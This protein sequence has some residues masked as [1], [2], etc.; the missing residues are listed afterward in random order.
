MSDA[1]HLLVREEEGILI[2]T[3]NRPDKLKAMS[4]ELTQAL[5]EAVVQF[6]DTPD[7]KWC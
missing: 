2:A 3:F 5:G 6:R 7:L 1:P 4:L